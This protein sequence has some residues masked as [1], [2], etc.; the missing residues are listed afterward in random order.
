MWCGCS[1]Q[2]ELD[3]I[4]SSSS[5][6]RFYTLQIAHLR[7]THTSSHSDVS[8]HSHDKISSDHTHLTAPV[9]APRLRYYAWAHRS[10]CIQRLSQHAPERLDDVLAVEIDNARRWVARNV[11][12]FSALHH[13]AACLTHSA[14]EGAG[15][16]PCSGVSSTV[17]SSGERRVRNADGIAT[18]L[19]WAVERAQTYPHGADALWSHARVLLAA[20]DDCNARSGGDER[21]IDASVR[22]G[23]G[24]NS[25]CYGDEEKRS[26]GCDSGSGEREGGSGSGGGGDAADISSG[27]GDRR[28]W[29]FA[30]DT[31]GRHATSAELWLHLR[32]GV[33]GAIPIEP[34]LLSSS[35]TPAF[36]FGGYATPLYVKVG[37]AT[38]IGGG[39]GR[40]GEDCGT[41]LSERTVV[42]HVL[43]ACPRCAYTIT[44]GLVTDQGR[45]A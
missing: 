29:L 5:F 44:Q 20:Q 4:S 39:G 14:V 33:S 7:T 6:T 17:N 41:V 15:G 10:W 27:V 34:T 21:S 35:N 24:V 8:L 36:F 13:L 16:L 1:P 9:R 43:S 18:A 26:G 40:V 22:A 37:D 19:Q 23:T 28:R 12:D 30:S 31:E 45:N 25:S 42:V 3:L 38:Q 2:K 32:T 11:A